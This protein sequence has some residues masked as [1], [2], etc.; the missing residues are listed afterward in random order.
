MKIP[1]S[2]KEI[3]N[4]LWEHRDNWSDFISPLE[5]TD[6]FTFETENDIV[7]ISPEKLL[8]NIGIRKVVEYYSDVKYLTLIGVEVPLEKKDDSTIRA[9]FL[10]VQEGAPGIGIIELK[11]STQTER[12]ALT[13]LL[14]YSKHLNTLFPTHCIE[15]TILVLIS[16]LKVRTTREAYLQSLLF[17]RKKI[18]TLIPSFTDSNSLES[19]VLKPY[20][21]TL[22]DF[23]TL[24]EVAFSK[25]NFDVEV[26]V[27][28]GVDS[29]WNLPEVNGAPS[30]EVKRNMNRISS[31]AAQLMEARQIHGF[32]YTQ[33]SWEELKMPCPNTLVLVGFNPYKIA[34]DVQYKKTYPN[35]PISKIPEIDDCY[36]FNLADII[37]GLNKNS[38]D[39]HEDENHL[40]W[41]NAVWGSHLGILGKEIVDTLNLNTLETSVNTDRGSMTWEQ[42]ES[43]FIENIFC[44]NFDLK[45]TGIIRE[46]YLE[47]TRI[48]YQFWK[49]FKT[50]PVQG[51][52]YGWAVETLSSHYLFSEF[53]ERMF[54]DPFGI[55]EIDEEE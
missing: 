49:K 30:H 6:E 38:K 8:Y 7:N 9:D 21:P 12:E 27:W 43:S 24:S 22:K 18:F 35:I 52:I 45:P 37:P 40:F 34:S 41:L 51:D 54:G 10:G 33:Q 16:P 23:A 20:I 1:F 29:F 19:L 25:R 39:L 31:Y 47:L 13:E 28:Y 36:G 48:D 14:A 46:L 53:L 3:Q 44:H 55:R 26:I 32:T 42:Y 2:E 50:H 5:T 17:D 4:F 15:D 11:R